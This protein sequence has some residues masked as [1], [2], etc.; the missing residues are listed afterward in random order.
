[1]DTPVYAGSHRR[2]ASLILVSVDGLAAGDYTRLRNLPAFR[3]LLNSGVCVRRVKGVFPTQTY[4]LHASLVTGTYPDRHGIAANT[5]LKPGDAGDWFWYR[6]DLRVPTLYDE[7]NEAGLRVATLFWPSA[8]GAAN[9]YVL[10]EILPTRRGEHLPGL[11]LK[12][13]TAGYV[14][15]MLLRYGYL[16]RG[17]RRRYLD[18]F[19]TACA[20]HLIRRRRADLLLLH[21]FDLDATRH[22]TGAAS[23]EAEEVLGEQDRRLG[24][25]LAA[26]QA[27]GRAGQTAVVVSGDHAHRDVRR[28]IHINTALRQ[29]GLQSYDAGGRLDR[30]DAWALS[31]D[32]SAQVLLRRP[33]NPNLRRRVADVLARMQQDPQSGIAA[34]LDREQLLALRAGET[35]DFALEAG[36]GFFFS[37]RPGPEAVS[38]ACPRYRA[39]HGYLPRD[40]DYSALFLAAGPGFRSGE[41]IERAGIVD[42]GTTLA[43]VLGLKLPAAEGRVL[44]EILEE[45]EG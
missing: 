41:E 6:R 13:G 26:L 33:D 35:V 1:M 11:V 42:I 39:A 5:R 8:G 21:L 19:A 28:R 18:N 29:A 20:C 3:S 9:K 24:R 14:L 34:V 7:A 43:H 38:E 31:C 30:W 22:R 12:A 25:I 36:A 40:D 32:G 16:L 15:R 10:P 4:P 44:G 27:S 37:S 2:P 45:S 17:L 23:P